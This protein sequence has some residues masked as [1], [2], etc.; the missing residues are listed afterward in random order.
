MM[1][2][3][4][5]IPVTVPLVPTVA[6]DALLLLH[7]PPTSVPGPRVVVC[8]TQIPDVPVNAGGIGLTVT[9]IVA[10]HPV[11]SVYVIVAVPPDIPVTNPEGLTVAILVALLLHEPPGDASVKEVV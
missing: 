10:K 6:T 3:P 5:D 7:T 8:P 4:N 11:E 2:V 9:I 1:A